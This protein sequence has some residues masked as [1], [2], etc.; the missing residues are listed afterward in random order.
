MDLFQRRKQKWPA[1]MTILFPFFLTNCTLRNK[2]DRRPQCHFWAGRI[3]FLC[4]R[5]L[6]LPFRFSVLCFNPAGQ[7]HA[8]KLSPI[9]DV[10]LGVSAFCEEYSLFMEVAKQDFL[11]PVEPGRRK[12][13]PIIAILPR[14]SAAAGHGSPRGADKLGFLARL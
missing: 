3:L 13:S 12:G 14:I 11:F 9:F 7:R 6:K 1:E 2:P 8:F 10:M 4:E 5:R